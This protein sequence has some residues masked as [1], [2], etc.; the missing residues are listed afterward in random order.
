MK[1]QLIGFK[2]PSLDTTDSEWLD[3]LARQS[4]LDTV[5]L[6]DMA[7]SGHI[8]GSFSCME[9]LA[10][11]YSSSTLSPGNADCFDRDRIV[12]SNA[13]ISAGL[14]SILSNLGFLDKAKV[15]AEYRRVPGYVEG[16]PDRNLPG[17]DW[18]SGALGQGLSVGCGMALA[19]RERGCPSSVFVL[20]GDGEQQ[21]GQNTEAAEFAA[22]H[23]LSNLV[24]I[25]DNNR[26]QS[27][28]ATDDIL[29]QDL[30]KKYLAAGWNVQSV[31]GHD[32]AALYQAL[33]NQVSMDKPGV[34][35]AQTVMGKGLPSIE[36]NF[37]YHGSLP[38]ADQVREARKIFA[39]G[40]WSQTV[41]PTASGSDRKVYTCKAA[42]IPVF[43]VGQSVPCRS[44]VGP[45]LDA[46]ASVSEELARPLV[47]DCDV[48]GSTGTL[49]YAKT[50]P[51]KFVQ[52][53]IQEANAASVAGGISAS[54]LPVVFSTF[55]VFSLVQP[56]S[57]LR[58]NRLNQVSEK[59]IST[60]CGLDVG[61]DGKTHQCLEYISLAVSLI[62][63]ELL[64]PA[65][66]NQAAAMLAYLLASTQPGILAVGRSKKPIV[67]D[68]NGDPY[69]R[70][71]YAFTYGQADWLRQ[72]GKVNIISCGNMIE[73]ALAAADELNQGEHHVGV[74]NL[75][76]PKRLDREALAIAAE[77]GRV[78]VYED[79][80]KHGGLASLVAQ[81]YMENGILC[82]FETMAVSDPGG[83][84]GVATLY[85]MQ[86]L[87][88]TTLK[89]KLENLLE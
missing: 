34:V 1:T 49:A 89:Q 66:A 77:S 82:R 50:Y 6:I 78:L 65:D 13:H 28:G 24:A 83:S 64:I 9:I 5:N 44:V 26:L 32:V 88:T 27:N 80:Y 45:V 30:E 16:H 35:L 25:I 70:E 52:C 59:I 73:Y 58:M 29:A 40:D 56:Y 7:G 4:R 63:T 69:F 41:K 19:G 57:Q 84:A 3:D 72:P 61:E 23:G 42:S 85:Q 51:K 46:S 48:G 87:D 68:Q 36:N 43:P 33:R 17:V 12:V 53:G 62:G 60:H 67:A 20:M 14:Y 37:T 55:A 79:H 39:C 75:C 22:H 18:G 11:L 71:K 2:Q 8:G 54:G 74:L 15:F 31:D 81:Y 10:V 86:N 38:T 76:C 47:L 21:E